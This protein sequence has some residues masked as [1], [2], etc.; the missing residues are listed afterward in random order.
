MPRGGQTGCHDGYKF[1]FLGSGSGIWHPKKVYG[2]LSETNF[3]VKNIKEEL[4]GERREG[5]ISSTG[6][7]P[8]IVCT[9]P[10]FLIIIHFTFL[11]PLLGVGYPKIIPIFDRIIDQIEEYKM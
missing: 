5:S 11:A 9:V 1:Y 3:A 7:V 10:M 2:K 6:K 4:K 8:L